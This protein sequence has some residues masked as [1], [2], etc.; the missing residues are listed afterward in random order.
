MS[1]VITDPAA[2][3]VILGLGM[4]GGVVAAELALAGYKVAGI[5]KGPYW[6]YSSDFSET[7]YDEWGLAYLHKF[8][9]TNMAQP[10][11]GGPVIAAGGYTGSAPSNLGL[12]AGGT[13]ASIGSKFKA[14]QANKY[15]RSSTTVSLAVSGITVPTTDL[16]LDLDPV[17]NDIYGDP[18]TRFTQSYNNNSVGCANLITPLL[19]PLANKMG[20][21]NV[22]LAAP[23]ANGTSPG[24]NS[25]SIHIRG[26][27][28]M[29]SNPA[30]SAFNAWQQSWTV[31]NLFAAGE[32]QD[33]TPSVVTQGTHVIG[34]QSYLAAEGIK[35]YLQN[36]GPL[37]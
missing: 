16:L 21:A 29:G 31:N 32:A 17:Y 25:Y 3:V 18:L 8:D 2:D 6:N 26:G 27:A 5:D 24:P 15:T 14:A 19:V 12:A 13:A 7:K 11:I 20:L 34:A 23:A 22:T 35:K 9:H 36:P 10:G 4:V 30:T 1:T 33:T 28:K 37:V